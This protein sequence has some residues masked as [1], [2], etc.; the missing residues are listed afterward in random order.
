MMNIKKFIKQALIYGIGGTIA[1]FSGLLTTPI[2]TRFLDAEGFGELDLATMITSIII[3]MTSLETQ[4][5]YARFYY[6]KQKKNELSELTGSIVWFNFLV[7]LLLILLTILLYYSAPYI[8]LNLNLNLNL[9]FPIVLSVLPINILSL[10]LV[11]FRFEN[12]AKL[13]SYFVISNTLLTSF[14]GII[15]VLVFEPKVQSILWSNVLVS[16]LS[17]FVALFILRKNT[18][19]FKFN[20]KLLIEILKYGVPLTPA[21]AGSWL[22][23]SAARIF[24]VG[25]LSL[26]SLGIY[27]L[28]LKI[29]LIFKLV[30]NAFNLTWSP[31]Q[32]KLFDEE[33]SEEKLAQTI[34]LFIPIMFFIAIII[35]S[36][37]PILV[38][39][40]ATPEFYSAIE[41]LSILVV[42]YLWDSTVTIF[43][44]G[45]NWSKK[46]YYN[47]IGSILSGIIVVFFLWIGNEKYGLLLASISL[48]IGS[49]LNSFFVLLTSQINH[50]IPY[51]YFKILGSLLLTLSFTFTS[52]FIFTNHS[53]IFL[54]QGFY[55]LVIGVIHL[56][57][58]IYINL[59]EYSYFNFKKIKGILK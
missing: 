46:T 41:L 33:K 43:A 47:S 49:I 57:L 30:G 32:I 22:K 36:L 21:I 38:N 59:N 39:L 17:C 11:S 40:L 19:K 15:S 16:Y 29:S 25:A 37:S 13:H 5:G 14:F 42:A 48:L 56:I 58:M 4:S 1:K 18:G 9:V 6:E 27:A 51:S 10:S 44:S 8:F 53:F 24:I 28:A 52:Y 54:E 20:K 2:Y 3:I 23:E 35:T 45:N 31:L 50:L 26:S 7:G 12:K 55:V 34:N